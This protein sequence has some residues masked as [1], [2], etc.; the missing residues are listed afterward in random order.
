MTNQRETKEQKKSATERPR[1]RA[2]LVQDSEDGKGSWTEITGL[3]PT[4]TGKGFSGAIR[5]PVAAATGRLVIL[6]AIVNP[7][8][9]VQSC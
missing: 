3:W 8:K 2:W 9:E 7:G 6:P 4:K 5:Q 1:Y